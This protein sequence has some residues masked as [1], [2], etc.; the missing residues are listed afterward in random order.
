MYQVEVRLFFFLVVIHSLSSLGQEN[1]PMGMGTGS[2]VSPNGAY[3]ASWMVM[4]ANGI[5]SQLIVTMDADTTGWIAFGYAATAN[6]HSQTDSVVGWVP[7]NG[8]TVL[9]DA[10]SNLRT[11]P[12]PDDGVSGNDAVLMDSSEVNGVTRITF[13][14]PLNTG[15]IDDVIILDQTMFL[16]WAYGSDDGQGP[17][18]YAQHV[19][20]GVAQV[21]LLET[22]VAVELVAS[23][24]GDAG[25]GLA[26][27]TACCLVV[28][29]LA[30]SI[31]YAWKIM[32]SMRNGHQLLASTRNL[33]N[34][35]DTNE[36]KVTNQYYPAVTYGLWH[37]SAD[38]PTDLEWNGV[39]S[40]SQSKGRILLPKKS[41]T[42]PPGSSIF[43]QLTRT[44]VLGQTQI[45][46][47][48]CI[49]FV[50]YIVVNVLWI[51]LWNPVGSTV[52]LN[53]GYI[54][55][56]NSMV[57][58]L[59]ASRHSF[60]IGFL[61]GLPFERRLPSHRW[62]GRFL[63]LI[64]TLHVL[65]YWVGWFRDGIF[66]QQQFQTPKYIFG[67][68]AW[69]CSLLIA[70]SS[71]NW[72]R[73]NYF[74]LFWV[75]HVAMFLGFY[76]FATIHSYEGMAVYVIIFAVVYLM[77]HLLRL[78]G[79]GILAQPLEGADLLA[80]GAIR[81]HF[82]RPRQFPGT[83][84]EVGQYVYLN[85]PSIALFQWHPFTLASGPKNSMA[86]VCIRSLGD[87]T[88]KLTEAIAAAAS[89][90]AIDLPRVRVDGPY[91][92]L[93]FNYKRY[94]NM[95][96]VG[97]GI[98]ITPL[99]SIIREIYQLDVPEALRSGDQSI[100]LQHVTLIWTVPT[101][102]EYG[103]YSDQLKKAQAITEQN[104]SFPSL[105]INVF[106][107]RQGATS[108]EELQTGR[109]N[110]TEIFS[111]LSEQIQ[112]GSNR[113]NSEST[114]GAVPSSDVRIT[115]PG[116]QTHR[117]AVVACGPNAIIQEVWDQTQMRSDQTIRYDLHREIFEF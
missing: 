33:Q 80:G 54:A 81:L 42:G 65:Y 45:S 6:G 110:F 107:S 103:W 53:L 96:L 94:P 114:A 61:S 30:R 31:R 116:S 19:E 88:A 84:A 5:Q 44:R 106:V 29:F 24:P 28:L 34:N 11:T 23:F 50:M 1:L 8:Q 112:L 98:G 14:K 74:N 57:V 75:T 83:K 111:N 62:L 109:P 60:I 69:I 82:R 2:F 72:I 10:F 76:T 102:A 92:K 15:N 47:L 7:E 32:A 27:T 17:A 49:A 22:G 39:D 21:N 41:G 56:A 108:E 12:V 93:S 90:D 18:A 4:Q 38:D 89:S 55:A 68:I 78:L 91:G 3:R 13:S 79:A 95:V 71:A 67:G 48:H 59:V 77:D 99:M 105:T 58:G 86:E 16:A 101:E 36:Q 40:G 73:R 35:P 97:G 63:V 117:V 25:R 52:G 115:L 70:I 37:P 100:W 9:I 43:R 87:H 20:R 51:F 46:L 26:L 64:V 85:F 66:V 104:L 113:R